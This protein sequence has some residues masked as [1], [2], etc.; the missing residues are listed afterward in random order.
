[1][2]IKRSIYQNHL[3]HTIFAHTTYGQA[4]ED[5]YRKKENQITNIVTFR[6]L[7]IEL[8]DEET[9]NKIIIELMSDAPPERRF[10]SDKPDG[11]LLKLALD[12]LSRRHC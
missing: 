11:K 10:G 1:M 4:V 7:L 8:I 5:A 6:E 2:I 9:T 3:Q 12:K